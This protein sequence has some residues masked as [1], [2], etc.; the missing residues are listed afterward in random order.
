MKTV[1]VKDLAGNNNL[2]VLDK[3]VSVMEVNASTCRINMSEGQG[4]STKQSLEDMRKL[5]ED[6]LKGEKLND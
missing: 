1:I 3:L 4:F 6:N 5:I 2:I